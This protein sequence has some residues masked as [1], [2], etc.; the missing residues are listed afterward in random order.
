MRATLIWFATTL[1]AGTVMAQT[2]DMQLYTS[3]AEVQA[4]IAKAKKERRP[5]QPIFS[6]SLLKLA[7]YRVSVEYSAVVAPAAIHEK[8]AEMVYVI[9]GGATLITGGKLIGE[10]RMNA[11][12]LIG[13]GIEGGESRPLSKGDFYI[14]PEGVPHWFNNIQ[15]VLVQMTFKVPRPLPEK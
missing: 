8:V 10:K 9:E 13:S 15:E 4:L 5:D 3:S 12:N 1:F 6:Q 11:D 7:P 14:V 2:P